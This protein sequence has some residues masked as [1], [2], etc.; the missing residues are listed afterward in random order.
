MCNG[1]KPA[2]DPKV[3]EKQQPC[4]VLVLVLVLVETVE[5][6]QKRTAAEERKGTEDQSGLTVHH[7]RIYYYYCYYH[8]GAVVLWLER[9]CCSA[10]DG[11]ACALVTGDL[12]VHLCAFLL[13]PSLHRV[14]AVDTRSCMLQMHAGRPE[15]N[16]GGW[17]Q[18]WT[19]TPIPGHNLRLRGLETGERHTIVTEYA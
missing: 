15:G 16:R 4:V 9:V 17:Q 11:W 18:W 13:V 14:G 6:E 10:A 8:D 12:R 2:S 7:D 5:K 1:T 19:N 3:R